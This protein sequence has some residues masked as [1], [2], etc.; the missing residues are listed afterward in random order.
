MIPRPPRS[1]ARSKTA[2]T[3]TPVPMNPQRLVSQFNIAFSLMSIIPLLICSYLITVKFFSISILE[4]I[5]GFY[6]LLAVTFA[7]LGLWAGRQAIG[8]I[9]R[10]LVETNAKLERLN[11]QQAAFVSNVAHEFRSPLTAMKGAMDN[12][13][14]GLYGSLSGE[15]R[16]PV[17]M[18]Q[19]ESN[20]LKR[21][22]TDL[23]DLARIEA[24]KM[25]M[26]QQDVVV[27]EI[28]G[29][30]VQ[31]FTDLAKKRGISLTTE[32]LESPAT[33]VGDRDRLQQV[34][35]NL[36]ANATKF[37]EK[38]NV[39]VRLTANGREYQVEVI[40]TGPGIA[41]EDL[42]RIFNKFE[43]VGATQTEEGSG[44]GLPIAK[45]IVDL[46][47]GRIWVESRP[48]QG[49]RFI[50][51]LPRQP[52]AGGGSAVAAEVTPVSSEKRKPSAAPTPPND[53]R[54]SG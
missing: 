42:E 35:V 54:R 15:Q 26:A 49:S 12:L 51:Q 30:S 31:L 23:L 45:D 21:L 14:D 24:G 38:G 46:H 28:L 47:H 13:A 18:C 48:G 3:P 32:L 1:A 43:R 36:L 29:A 5:N 53:H 8:Y 41:E 37:T 44:L 39:R 19:R 11:N 17:A 40:D 9:I 22:V 34:F 27:Q 52:Q 4:G 6:L 20:R 2:T 16:E 7:L 10:R 25:P 50:V 33:I